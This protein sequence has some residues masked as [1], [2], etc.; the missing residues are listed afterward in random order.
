MYFGGKDCWVS[1]FDVAGGKM[2]ITDEESDFKVE[3]IRVKRSVLQ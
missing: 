3:E 2:R 1:S